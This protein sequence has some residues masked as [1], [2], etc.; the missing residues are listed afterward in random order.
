MR[1]E[2]DEKRYLINLKSIKGWTKKNTSNGQDF[3]KLL[4][5]K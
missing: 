5:H 4:I 3:M 1:Y 2:I